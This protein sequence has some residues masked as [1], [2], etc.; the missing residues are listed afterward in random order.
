MR[1]GKQFNVTLEEDELRRIDNIATRLGKSRAQMLRSFVLGGLRDMEFLDQSGIFSAVFFTD[2][3]LSKIK[4]ALIKG[5]IQMGEDGE[6]E[7]KEK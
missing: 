1:K 4:Q 6:L 2:K 5:R 7:F 3:V